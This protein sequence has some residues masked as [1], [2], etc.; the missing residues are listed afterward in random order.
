MPAPTQGLLFEVHREIAK[1]KKEKRE[2]AK[3]M[4]ADLNGDARY[5]EIQNELLKLRGEK[6]LI[7]NRVLAELD[8]DRAAQLTI[9]IKSAKAQLSNIAL[10]KLIKGEPLNLQ[11]E[12]GEKLEPVVQI[13][14]I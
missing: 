2:L 11:D 4:K 1:M 8:L 3:S 7:E 9:E 10:T 13:K 12:N 5:K 14:F 6:K